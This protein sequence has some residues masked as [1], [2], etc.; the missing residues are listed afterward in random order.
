MIPPSLWD[1]SDRRWHLI[2][3]PNKN[4]LRV[5]WDTVINKAG[6]RGKTEWF[7]PRKGHYL[8]P[9]SAVSLR[10]N[11]DC[12]VC[13]INGAVHF[14][15]P[16]VDYV[17]EA[18]SLPPPLSLLLLFTCLILLLCIPIFI[19][20]FLQLSQ[21]MVISFGYYDHDLKICNM[22]IR[23]FVIWKYVAKKWF[24]NT[25]SHLFP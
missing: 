19:L 4:T 13:A 7:L 15:V 23:M 22:F 8:P 16:G 25:H 17:A 1:I 5:K 21:A 11:E 9:L 6:A 24:F 3:S 18:T 10:T 12:S 2:Y 14:P 20:M